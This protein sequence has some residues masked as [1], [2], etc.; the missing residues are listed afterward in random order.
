MVYTAGTLSLAALEMLVQLS[1]HKL[2]ENYIYI[3]VEFSKDRVHAIPSEA[4]PA[5]WNSMPASFS[6]KTIGDN[7]A[8][9]NIS[10]VLEV[11]SVI[12]PVEMN[13]LFNPN[14]PEFRSLK[15]HPPHSFAFD[16]RL[17]GK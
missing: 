17:S 3:E 7:W 8:R 2:L 6:T 10:L 9:S 16:Q 11:P 14:H 4:L 13:H 12:I 1:D 5:Q 15:F